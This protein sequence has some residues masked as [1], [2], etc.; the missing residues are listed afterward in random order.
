MYLI[1]SEDALFPKNSLLI[2]LQSDLPSQRH[3]RMQIISAL[4]CIKCTFNL[5]F[6]QLAH[7]CKLLKYITRYS[8]VP[9]KR[10]GAFN[11]T[12]EKNSRN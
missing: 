7:R 10:K 6:R 12:E 2:I 4:E 8:R 5:C 11:R 1:R 3:V 9:N